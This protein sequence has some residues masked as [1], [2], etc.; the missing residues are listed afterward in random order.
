[1]GQY[2]LTVNVTKRQ[3][4]NPHK[5]GAGLK[6]MEFSGQGDS[7]PQALCI[8]LA[9]S[10]GRGGGDL[11]SDDHD[12]D[13]LVGSWAGDQIVVA[14]DYDDPWLFVPEDLKGKEYTTEEYA[15]SRRGS[16]LQTVKVKQKFGE[17]VRE[18]RGENEAESQ[19]YDETLYSAAQAFFEDIS[20][21]IIAVVAK[22][23]GPYHPWA[24][25][26][27]SDDGW[28]AYPE[29]GVL[30]EIDPKKPAG[31]KKA[32]TAYKKNAVAPEQNMVDTIAR[33]LRRYPAKRAEVE[34]LLRS[35]VLSSTSV[36]SG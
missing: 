11:R 28:R 14:G 1:M 8:L 33:Y 27:L 4:L 5:F 24:A 18:H 31:G 25:M 16:K 15:P 22:G 17:R 9:H 19:Y 36:T 2:Y 23:D 26:D 6:L 20:D 34:A 7:L 30:P 32:Y 3:Y 21:K 10:N 35:Q 13:K 12:P 29:A